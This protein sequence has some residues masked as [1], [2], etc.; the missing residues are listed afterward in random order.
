MYN[1]TVKVRKRIRLKKRAKNI[2]LICMV[3][4]VIYSYISLTGLLEGEAFG[5]TDTS[6]RIVVKEGDTLWGLAKKYGPENQD[7]RKT[8]FEIKKINNIT[9]RYIKPGEVLIMP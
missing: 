4:F 6:S 3:V 9:A 8:V 2:L 7:I 1:N 5:S